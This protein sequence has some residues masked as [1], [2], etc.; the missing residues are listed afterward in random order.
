[1][2]TTE[3]SKETHTVPERITWL[4]SREESLRNRYRGLDGKKAAGADE[5]SF[6]SSNNLVNDVVLS[7]L[8]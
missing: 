2:R 8:P 1:M 5:V 6:S 3:F 7:L 4:S